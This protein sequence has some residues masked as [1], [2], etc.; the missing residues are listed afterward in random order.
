VSRVSTDYRR[1]LILLQLVTT[2]NFSISPFHTHAAIHYITH[3]VFSVSCLQ[4][5]SGND[6]QWQTFP[7][8][9][10]PEL[11]PYLSH[12]NSL[13]T[14][15][16]L[17]LSHDDSFVPDLVSILRSRR[18][19]IRK[20]NWPEVKVKLRPRAVSQS[21]LFSRPIAELSTFGTNLNSSCP[22]N[23]HVSVPN[24]TEAK[25]WKYVASHF[26]S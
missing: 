7:F 10:V 17:Q 16:Q 14:P 9:W 3:V 12:S 20:K 21:A 22:K 24:V 13:L 6:F 26:T 4:Q 11:F 19:S 15:Q 5:S 18:R 1:S 25:N 8:L 2:T 23:R